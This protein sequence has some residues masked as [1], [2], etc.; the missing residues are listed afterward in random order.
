MKE[1]QAVC[2]RICSHC[3]KEV[4]AV[5]TGTRTALCKSYLQ[6]LRELGIET[7]A[8]RLIECAPLRL[9]HTPR[10]IGRRI[11]LPVGGQRG[12]RRG[13]RWALPKWRE[14]EQALPVPFLVS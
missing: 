14:R 12:K 3:A 7:A 13:Y 5:C 10:H 1:A 4:P 8:Y 2:K 11:G 9:P 6:A